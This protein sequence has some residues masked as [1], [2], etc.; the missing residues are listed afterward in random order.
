MPLSP[1]ERTLR[2][3]LAAHTLYSK[4]D[5][6]EHTRPARQAFLNSFEEQ[7]DPDRKLD[8]AE[9]KRRAEHAKKAHFARLSLLSSKARRQ[10]KG[11]DAE[12]AAT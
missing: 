3:R 9:R 4:V 6:T 11:A 7:V 1:S 2:A 10:R 5:A 8:P 12:E